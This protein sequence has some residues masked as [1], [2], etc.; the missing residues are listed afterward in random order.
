MVFFYY[1][2]FSSRTPSPDRQGSGIDKNLIEKITNVAHGRGL[3]TFSFS[4]V[5]RISC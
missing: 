4:T 3:K 5:L 2:I 1:K